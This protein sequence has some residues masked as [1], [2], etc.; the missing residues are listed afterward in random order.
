MR[1]PLLVAALVAAGSGCSAGSA[2]AQSGY[3][4]YQAAVNA[5]TA[6]T[7]AMG[8]AANRGAQAGQYDE[9]VNDQIIDAI[10][11]KNLYAEA[12]GPEVK[13][14]VEAHLLAALAYRAAAVTARNAGADEYDNA[15]LWHT[16]GQYWMGQANY[17]AAKTKFEWAKTDADDALAKYNEAFILLAAAEMEVDAAYECWGW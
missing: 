3:E 15:V 2:P 8:A 9:A 17:Q 4:L 16:D 5:R 13:A 11:W 14:Q 10:D 1:S 6:A 12:M 7:T